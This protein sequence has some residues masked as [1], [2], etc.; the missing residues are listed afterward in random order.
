MTANTVNYDPGFAM[1]QIIR[2]GK[3]GTII[4][5]H[6]TDVMGY[7]GI[8]KSRLVWGSPSSLSGD[9]VLDKGFVY[10]TD[11][12]KIQT[13]KDLNALFMRLP[14]DE[15]AVDFTVP[16]NLGDLTYTITLRVP[17]RYVEKLP[18]AFFPKMIM[19]YPGPKYSRA[20]LQLAPH[21]YRIPCAIGGRGKPFGVHIKPIF[22]GDYYDVIGIPNGFRTPRVP[23]DIGS[24]YEFGNLAFYDIYP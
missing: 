3:P 13:E 23:P 12:S 22:G 19:L 14:V 15:C 2:S 4:L 17:V 20:T 16:K 21:I 24:G 18:K 1:E 8:I 6:H 5:Y 9:T 11:I 7:Y 10:L